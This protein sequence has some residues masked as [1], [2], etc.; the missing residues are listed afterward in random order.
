MRHEKTGE[1]HQ[2]R[3][4]LKINMVLPKQQATFA[5]IILTTA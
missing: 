3:K 4:M 5:M 2:K 1:N